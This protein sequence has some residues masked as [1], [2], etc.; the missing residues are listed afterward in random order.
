[1]AFLVAFGIKKTNVAS[2]T[3]LPDAHVEA[4]SSG[5]VILAAVLLKVGGYG[6]IRFLLP[7]TSDAGF[8]L[9]AY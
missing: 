9:I 4:P 8:Y 2:S 7:I 3:W 5:S 1:M 6:L